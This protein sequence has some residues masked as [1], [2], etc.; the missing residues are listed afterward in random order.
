MSSMKT[1]KGAQ[2]L[3]LF[4]EAKDLKRRINKSKEIIS[5]NSNRINKHFL[6]W[7][8]GEECN[9]DIKFE[10]NKISNFLNLL[11]ENQKETEALDAEIWKDYHGED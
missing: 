6:T 3:E 2:R 11:S 7:F 5:Y 4:K 8:Q 9:R 1:D 10:K